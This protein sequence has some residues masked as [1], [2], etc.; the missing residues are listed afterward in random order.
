M[1]EALGE[2]SQIPEPNENHYEAKI[3]D[4]LNLPLSKDLFKEDSLS[5]LKE[6]CKLFSPYNEKTKELLNKLETL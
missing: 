1:A 4:V 5:I 6:H 2:L 3:V